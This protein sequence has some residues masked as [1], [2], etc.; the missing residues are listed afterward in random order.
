MFTHVSQDWITMLQKYGPKKN[1]FLYFVL[2]IRQNDEL[3][4]TLKWYIENT[5]PSFYMKWIK[6]ILYEMMKGNFEDMNNWT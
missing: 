1:W 6:N 5:F 4:R 3:Q 2:S